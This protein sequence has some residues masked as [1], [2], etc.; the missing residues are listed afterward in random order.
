M[1]QPSYDPVQK[2]A[3]CHD[4][5]NLINR[6]ET[7]QATVANP[8]S[9][10]SNDTP[11]GP[12][13]IEDPQLRALVDIMASIIL[14][15]SAPPLPKP[16]PAHIAEVMYLRASCESSGAFSGANPAIKRD[17]RTAFRDF[18]Y[19]ARN[20]YAAAWFKIGR[21][22]ENFGDI[23]HAKDAFERGVKAGDE[24]SLYVSGVGIASFCA[25]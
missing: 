3:W 4:V 15:L 6:A 21:D 20:G 22:Y 1:Q 11:V 8:T 14:Q 13:R 18:E 9:V 24:R 23:S 25:A 12:L 19:A 5:L 16:A 17:P 2:V 7:L 10:G